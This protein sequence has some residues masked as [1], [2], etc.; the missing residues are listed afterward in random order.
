MATRR[1]GTNNPTGR[2]A[3]LTSRPQ[4]VRNLAGEIAHE[5]ARRQE[6]DGARRLGF[7]FPLLTPPPGEAASLSDL[8]PLIR[9][10]V[11]FH[12][13]HNAEPE[14]V[15]LLLEVG[16]LSELGA[17]CDATNH[18]RA[19]LYL[20]SCASYLPE[21]EDGVAL[22]TAHG[23]YAAAGRLP[24]ALRCALKL[25][26]GGA[27]LVA[28]T[29]QAA[30]DAGVRRQL[31]HM[32]FRAG[33]AVD[34]NA[35]PFAVTAD[36]DALKDIVSGAGVS[37]RYLALA[38]DLDVMEAKTAEDIYKSHLVEGRGPAAG[39]AAAVDSARANLAATFVNAL[40]NC[41]FGADK[42]LT[43]PASGDA[44]SWIYK[45]KE[46]GKTAAAASLGC[47]LLWDVEGGLPQIDKYLYAA[48]MHVVAGAM[49][50]VGIL[51]TGSR[52]E[53]DP[54]FALLHEAVAH[55]AVEVRCGALLGLGLAY[56]GAASQ[57]LAGL[58]APILGD[59]SVGMEVVAYAALAL[60]LSFCGSADGSAA[61]A[62]LAPLMCRGEVDLA[63]PL[64]KLL[65]LSLGLVF[66]GRGGEAEAT[67]EVL[68]TLAPHPLGR[69][70]S[71]SLDGCA[72]A[73]TGNVLKVQHLL[74]VVG[75]GAA[76][77]VAAAEEDGMLP[78]VAQQPDSAAAPPPAAA[79]PAPAAA[80]P[81]SANG[82]A[83]ASA[84][85]ATAAAAAAAAA[86]VPAAADAPPGSDAHLGAAVLGIALVALGE[87]T[88]SHM[89]LRALE[90]ILQYGEP[91]ARAAVPLAMALLSISKPELGVTDALARLA[92]DPSEAVAGAALLG[93]GLA[94]AG[95]NNARV[96]ASLRA[97]SGYHG[98]DPGLLYCTR[99]AQGLVHAG[100]GLLGLHP[101]VADRSVAHP[102]SLAAL[103]VVAFCGLQL[104]D[105]LLGKH[106]CLFF[107]LVPALHPRSLATI[108]EDGRPLPVPVRV[109][110]AVDV[111]AA[112]GRPKS[113]TGWQTHTTPVLLAVG[114]RAELATDEYLPLSPLLEGVVILRKNPNFLGKS[115]K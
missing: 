68:K 1:A 102:P 69:F 64:A 94:S 80:A 82:G 111:T 12:M 48:D 72:F 100:K 4:Y 88:G 5:W 22:R 67:G 95:S 77:A 84:A 35:G 78:L 91:P 43:S 19:A 17:H 36:V 15:D 16:L 23:I 66:L 107:A 83:I 92:H 10:V 20:L 58:V 18:G 54:A 89:A 34:V 46:A 13:A 30:S 63:H 90:H 85:A 28:A 86:A 59:E 3:A 25:R 47:I 103:A 33:V 60:G 14:A 112:A 38:R 7:R 81:A 41:G 61:A 70:A 75:E 49:L 52:S 71:A 45:N 114:E 27:E 76:A 8:L 106:A 32:L 6:A 50:A 21:P 93:L 11:P 97:L 110:E 44:V 105:T 65:A 74:A 108:G 115:D 113:I 37:A 98:R 42:L 51:T 79:A 24:E 99:L 2:T 31:A 40:V 73:A 39:G 53:M 55:P 109:G 101:L 29:W 26:G 57:P 96:A 62:L 104:G 9:A 87:E 56:C